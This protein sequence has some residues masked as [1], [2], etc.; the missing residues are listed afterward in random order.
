MLASVL[1][2]VGVVVVVVVVVVIGTGCMTMVVIATGVVVVVGVL[3]TLSLLLLASVEAAS[4]KLVLVSPDD[5]ATRS[6][7]FSPGCRRLLADWLSPTPVS[8]NT[9]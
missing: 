8:A 3:L 1:D 6:S 4:K 5:S 2:G 7:T 9:C